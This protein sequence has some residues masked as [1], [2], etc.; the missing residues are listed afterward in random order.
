MVPSK[1]PSET[2]RT[3]TLHNQKVFEAKLNTNASYI[4][5]CTGEKRHEFSS[6]NIKR[7]TPCKGLY[8]QVKV[9]RSH[10]QYSLT[11]TDCRSQL[12]PRDTSV[13]VSLGLTDVSSLFLY[14]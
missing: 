13:D 6:L 10:S 8:V 11:T 14:D 12:K 9:V 5:Q 3:R 1:C 7:Q 2:A 4:I